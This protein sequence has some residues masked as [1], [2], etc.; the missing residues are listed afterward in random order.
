MSYCTQTFFCCC[1]FWLFFS[2]FLLNKSQT[3]R[4]EFSMCACVYCVF[5]SLPSLGLYGLDTLS[6]AALSC[7]P[8]FVENSINCK[9]IWTE[10]LSA[11]MARA[12]FSTILCCILFCY[13]VVIIQNERIDGNKWGMGNIRCVEQRAMFACACVTR[14][15]CMYHCQTFIRI[16]MHQRIIS[17]SRVTLESITRM[18][19]IWNRIWP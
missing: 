2:I 19:S 15:S 6:L 17:S 12:L 10:R 14:L 13:T 1:M 8:I 3:I 5:F 16:Y 11:R 18:R 7:A 4:G 9:T